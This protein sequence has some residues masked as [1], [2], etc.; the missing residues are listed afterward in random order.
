VCTRDKEG[1]GEK[2]NIA[3]TRGNIEKTAEKFM[4]SEDVTLI[5]LWL[6]K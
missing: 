4:T 1:A 2:T 5:A 3:R 6:P